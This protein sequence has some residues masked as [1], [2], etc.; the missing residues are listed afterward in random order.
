MAP[1]IYIFSGYLFNDASVGLGNI[2]FSLIS[3]DLYTSLRSFATL[4]GLF[5]FF[6]FQVLYQVY[7]LDILWPPTV[8]LSTL[9]SL[10]ILS[11]PYDSIMKLKVVAV[12]FE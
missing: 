6:S 11:C 5:F 8:L 7:I 2:V 3:S 4:C 1:N 9:Y 10:Q 12:H